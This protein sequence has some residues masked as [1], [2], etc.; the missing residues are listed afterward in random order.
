MHIKDIEN[1]IIE[2]KGFRGVISWLYYEHFKVYIRITKRMIAGSI[3]DTIDISSIEVDERNRHQ[4][5]FKQFL[6]DIENLA[7]KYRKIVYIESILNDDIIIH[8][9]KKDY[10]FTDIETTPNA[11]K[12][13][14]SFK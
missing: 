7:R 1:M 5:I 2:Y 6:V 9:K 14:K 11:F 4:G 12:S 10:I 13:F 8:L 3:E